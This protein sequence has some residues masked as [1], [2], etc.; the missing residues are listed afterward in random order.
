ML[1][2]RSLAGA[3]QLVGVVCLYAALM[4]KWAAFVHVCTHGSKSG[5]DYVL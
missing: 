2:R 1:V 5:A 4:V 3:A